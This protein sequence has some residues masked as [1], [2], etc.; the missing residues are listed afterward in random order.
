MNLKYRFF[1]YSLLLVMVF[2]VF[3]YQVPHFQYSIFKDYIAK[4]LCINR[5]KKNSCCQG[6]CFLEKQI[7]AIDENNSQNTSNNNDKN[8]KKIQKDEVKEFLCSYFLTIKPVALDLV[9]W[10][11]LV[12][13]KVSGFA[14]VIFVPPKFLVKDEIND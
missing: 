12:A 2:N 6:K 4:N 13:A 5:N 8:N 1:A 7:K 11:N 9:P 10:E 14:S 3:R